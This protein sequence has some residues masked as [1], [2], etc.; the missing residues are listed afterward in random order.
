MNSNHRIYLD[1]CCFNRPFDDQSQLRIRL[2]AQA[3][4][5]IQYMIKEGILDL[6]WSFIL[7]F[8]I[9]YNPFE[10]RRTQIQRWEKDAIDYIPASDN[11]YQHGKI[12]ME[13]IGLKPKD[14]LHLSAALAGKC[15]YLITTDDEIIKK[16]QKI[17][18][19]KVLDP[20]DFLK[21]RSNYYEN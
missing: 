18:D 17:V 13:N 2:E 5:A 9:L 6:V 20:I 19:I 4:I 10:N 15:Q 11:I 3:K 16:C 12:L 7:N 8:E 21:T 14:A 1:N